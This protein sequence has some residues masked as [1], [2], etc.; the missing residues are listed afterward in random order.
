MTGVGGNFNFPLFDLVSEKL[1][2]YGCE[3]FSPAD[4]ARKNIGSLE[5][6][7]KMGKAEL[8]V[9]VNKLFA[10][11]LVW[12]CTEADIV[13]MLAGWHQSLGATAERAVA[14]ATRRVIVRELDNIILDDKA[15]LRLGELALDLAR[16]IT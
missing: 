10:E 2:A 7:Q 6:I 15:A 11:E 8:Q 5:S 3:V 4:H 12:I 16:D 9:A 14:L 1:R 13:V